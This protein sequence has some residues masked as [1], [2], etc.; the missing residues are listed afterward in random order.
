ML[1]NYYCCGFKEKDID[2]ALSKD[3]DGICS[4]IPVRRQLGDYK[5]SKIVGHMHFAHLAKEKEADKV[6]I[7][8]VSPGA[9]GGSFAEKMHFP[10]SLLMSCMPCLFRCLCITHSCSPATS[11]EMGAARYVEVLTGEEPK[12]PTGSMPMSG[13]PFPCCCMMWGANGKMIDNRPLVPYFKDEALCEKAA[14]K[15]RE[16]IQQWQ[17]EVPGQQTMDATIH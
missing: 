2:W 16:R 8:S 17:T 3:Y 9:V 13:Y 11:L 14:T 7:S 10:V 4:C 15:V 5:N 1:P 6:H 12:W